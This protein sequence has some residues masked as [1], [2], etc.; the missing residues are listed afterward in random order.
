MLDLTM[1]LLKAL[2]TI[3]VNKRKPNRG[4]LTS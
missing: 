3:D 1:D 2:L 4:N